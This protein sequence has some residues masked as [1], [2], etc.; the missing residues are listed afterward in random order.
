VSD[1]R[2]DRTIGPWN[3]SFFVQVPPAITSA[4]D[5]PLVAWSDTRLGGSL[6]GTRTS[7]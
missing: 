6:A 5:G 1:V 7:P 3:L 4:D 2:I